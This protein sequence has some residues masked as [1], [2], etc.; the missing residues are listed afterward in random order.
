MEEGKN[1]PVLFLLF[2]FLLLSFTSKP[3]TD[4]KSNPPKHFVLV[5]GSCHGAWSWYKVVSVLK[6]RGHK[7]T[8]LDLA[9]SGVN[10]QQVL[11]LQ[12]ISEYFMPL[13]EF[14]ASLTEDEKVVLV[15]HS[16]G[17][18]AISHAMEHFPHKV[19]VAV[20]LTALMPGP[21]LNISTLY[22]KALMK[23]G[24]SLDNE[25]TY[26]DGPNKPPTT[27]KFG[28]RYLASLVYQLSPQ[29]DLDLAKTLL[30]P[31]RLF[32]EVDMA[33]VLA[34]SHSRYGSVSRIFAISQEDR[35]MNQDLQRWML[36]QNP[37]DHVI[38][39]AGSDH[40]VMLS[41]PIDLCLHLQ[42]IA[43]YLCS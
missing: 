37:P 8:A 7:V 40:M 11:E 30:R 29:Q 31:L 33:N 41:K 39:I 21:T 5:H 18:L 36:E 22:H 2:Y 43:R 35:V 19:A 1:H 12:S 6:S 24:P 15:G 38:K 14:M 27:F 26:D 32:S 4:A 17:G 20:F 34:L 16:L 3:L 9:A 10:H 23:E 25:Y 28:P 42:N 13:T